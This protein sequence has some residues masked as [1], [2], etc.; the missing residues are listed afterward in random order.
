MAGILM[1]GSPVNRVLFL[2]DSADT[3]SETLGSQVGTQAHVHANAMR[4]LL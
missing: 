2:D 1:A 4:W 3:S